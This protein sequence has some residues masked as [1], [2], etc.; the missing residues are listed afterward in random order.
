MILLNL[1]EKNKKQSQETN[2]MVE[3]NQKAQEEKQEMMQSMVNVS[4]PL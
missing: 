4:K 2:V 1:I 3:T